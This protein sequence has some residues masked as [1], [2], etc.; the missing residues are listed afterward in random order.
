MDNE[1]EAKMEMAIEYTTV[2][3]VRVSWYDDLG[4]MRESTF[5]AKRLSRPTNRKTAGK[6]HQNDY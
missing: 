3:I 2:I 4:N 5:G 1:R 6:F